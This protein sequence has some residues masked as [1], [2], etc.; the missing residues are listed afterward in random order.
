MIH[1]DPRHAGLGARAALPVAELAALD[2]TA[3]A[4]E[5]YDTLRLTLGIP[6]SGSDLVPEK[7]LL[8]ESGFEQ[9]N[10]VDFEKGCYVG[11]EVTA[12]TKYRGLVKKRL[13]PVAIDGPTPEAGTPV[14]AGDKEAGEMRSGG[15]G[16]GLALMRLEYLDGKTALAAGEAKIEPRKPD[17]AAF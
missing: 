3:G 8:M 6:A 12:R 15:P 1:E 9:L 2:L 7:S 11:Q 14:L 10:G 4:R 17:W 5:D 16:L 13:V